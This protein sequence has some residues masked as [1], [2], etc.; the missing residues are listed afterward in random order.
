MNTHRWI[1]GFVASLCLTLL[2]TDLFSAE[3][4]VTRSFTGAWDQVNQESQG[5][6]L[7]VVEQ[8]DDSRVA[9]VHWY[10][11]GQDRKSAWYLGVGHIVD[12]HIN[13][14]LYHS[15]DVGFMEDGKPGDDSVKPIGTMFMSFENCNSGTV[16]FDTNHDEV[17][18]GAFDISRITDIMN[19]HCSGGISDNMDS[20]ALF[21][22]QRID[23]VSTRE[24]MDASGHARFDEAPGH[25]GFEVD[26]NGLPDGN[27]HL[28]VGEHDCGEFAVSGGFGDIEFKSPLESGKH[29]LTFDPRG[30]Q[31]RIHDGAGE[32]LSSF[33]GIFE[34]ESH[35]HDGDDDHNYDCETGMGM[36][37][38]DNHGMDDCVEDGEVLEIEVELVNSGQLQG[39]KGEAEWEMSSS[40]IE[41]S[42][43]IEEVPA[44]NYPLVIA[45]QA[46]GTIVA[47]EM[48]HS[49]VFGRIMFRDPP[50]YGGYP[51]DF[52]PRGQTIEVMQQ[53]NVILT[54]DFPEK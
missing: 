40:H 53:G 7:Q 13:F 18:S 41:F 11:Y 1:A 2:A 28:Y 52:D 20:R 27:Y 37:H 50:M 16:T 23:L 22:E 42:V 34:R 3:L 10:T 44:G 54:V 45:G 5:I 30:M 21:G 35:G 47:H 25:N 26:T 32:I 49:G 19:M 38:D 51:L 15:E 8:A 17:G 36:G 29:L 4:L 14:D 33:D 31:I 46:V 12:D 48:M 39:A 43:E 24:G 6:N 9:V